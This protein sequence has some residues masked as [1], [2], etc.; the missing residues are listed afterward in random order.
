MKWRGR[1]SDNWACRE[2]YEV[3]DAGSI[4][5][6]QCW[7]QEGYSQQHSQLGALV[8]TQLI[9]HHTISLARAQLHNSAFC[10]AVDAIEA[11]LEQSFPSRP[12]WKQP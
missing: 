1:K 11:F 5:G 3:E 2:M 8:A 6:A 7:A 12:P 10:V 9:N 4:T